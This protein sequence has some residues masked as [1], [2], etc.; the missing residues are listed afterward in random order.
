MTD[1]VEQY[2]EPVPVGGWWESRYDDTTKTTTV[3]G[4]DGET[5]RPYTSVEYNGRPGLAVPPDD[6]PPPQ[7]SAPTGESTSGIVTWSWDGLT[8][9][10]GPQPP[11]FAHGTLAWAGVRDG[12]TISGVNRILPGHRVV[13]GGFDRGTNATAAI[14]AVDLN[15][16]ESEPSA[17]IAVP[18]QSVLDDTGLDG[19]MTELADALQGLNDSLDGKNRITRS[20]STPTQPESY[21][22]G[23]LWFQYDD[24]RVIGL[25]IHDGD[26]WATHSLNDQVISN[27][28]AGTITTGEFTA[29]RFAADS[30]TANKVLM[31]EA[32]ANSFA[33]LFAAFAE[34]FIGKLRADHIEVGSFSGY[35]IEGADIRS[36]SPTG[37]YV[38]V[39]NQAVRVF[40]DDGEGSVEETTSLGGTGSDR[41]IMR[42]VGDTYP[43]I[44]LDAATGDGSVRGQFSAD[45]LVVGGDPLASTLARIPRGI[46]DEFWA[47]GNATPNIGTTPYGLFTASWRLEPGRRYRV[48]AE[49]H[50]GGATG[51]LVYAALR[52]TT[53]TTMPGTG[54][55]P[56]RDEHFVID[57]GSAP[58]TKR[59]EWVI[60]KS[61]QNPLR[62]NVMLTLTL[63]SGSSAIWLSGERQ[64]R[65]WVEDLGPLATDLSYGMGIANIGT[66]YQPPSGPTPTP[67]PPV[68][69]KAT[70]TGH[71]GAA[72]SRSWRGGTVVSDALH[73]GRFDGI[74][75]Y[76]AIGFG[77]GTTLAND[78]AGAEIISAEVYLH[79]L[80]AWGSTVDTRVSSS[81]TLNAPSSPITTGTY[82]TTSVR[83]GEG[84][85]V[86]VGGF[87]TGSR[88][89]VLG[90]GGPTATANYGKFRLGSAPQLRVT[91][92]K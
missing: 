70:Y 28:D 82:T 6:V 43:S 31:D 85:W 47:S 19:A 24:S 73:H 54:T 32:M 81:T 91:Y 90:S 33:G 45:S 48:V 59:L 38:Q 21:E 76:S 77:P 35:L 80:S 41:L 1:E 55:T 7:P 17:Q 23:D 18:V 64:S 89:V 56:E 27:L 40:R 46:I 49:L 79:N 44:Q 5:D 88:T 34:A 78:I 29:E 50:V 61:Y 36:T 3:T 63:V 87:T 84:R 71:Y 20:Q 66:P 52:A 16:N 25:W 53:G 4:P 37:E 2:A 42:A 26:T 72:W 8:T 60:S 9:T 92:R 51:N 68:E 11:D 12:Q 74:Q 69:Q 14:V 65:F 30:V 10:G 86:P 83:E 22:A 62:F 13:T 39:A 67:P 75:R 58:T 57:T 15:G